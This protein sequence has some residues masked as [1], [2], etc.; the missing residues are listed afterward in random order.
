MKLDKVLVTGAGGF[1]GRGLTAQLLKVGHKVIAVDSSPPD[2]LNCETYQL[3]ICIPGALDGLLDNS[4]TLFHLAAHADVAS[5]VS[6]P[7]FN[8]K[9]NTQGTFE[10]L[11]SVR[12]AECRMIFPSTASVYDPSVIMP[13]KERSYIK[14]TSPYAAAKIAGEAYCSAYSRSYG[15]DIKIVRMFSV[16]GRGMFRFAIHD[17]VRKVEADSKKLVIL[18]DG[19]QIR[20]YLYIDDLLRG[21]IVI[22]EN[23]IPGE[24]Y[25]LAT[26]VPTKLLELAQNIAQIMNYPDI[27]ITP[28]GKS[29]PGDVKKW[30]ADIS[31][32]QSIGFNPQVKL[33]D[34]LKITIEWLRG[35]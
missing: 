19:H 8:Y 27:E 7:A 32:V 26:G 18:G 16:Y 13:I 2:D 14:P 22:A 35:R 9:I 10:I 29:F 1:I 31:K 11:E 33:N 6:K 28:S 12:K 3:D 20:D 23:G 5:S 15:L 4:T 24:E 21:L 25:N 17:I 30:Y 34:G